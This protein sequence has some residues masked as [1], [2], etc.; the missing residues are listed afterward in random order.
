M[1]FMH[2]MPVEPPNLT[3]ASQWRLAPA[4]TIFVLRNPLFI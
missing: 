4:A 1:E 2:E 3:A